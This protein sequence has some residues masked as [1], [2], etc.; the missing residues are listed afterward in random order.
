LWQ[1][2]SMSFFIKEAAA[3]KGILCLLVDEMRSL[4]CFSFMLSCPREHNR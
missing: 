2:F 3:K 4:S 1:R